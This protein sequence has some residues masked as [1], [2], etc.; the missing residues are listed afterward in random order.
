MC[1][2][3]FADLCFHIL[4]GVNVEVFQY[5]Q[6]CIGPYHM[7]V[8]CY[9]SESPIC[10]TPPP[11]HQVSN[12]M[13]IGEP[14]FSTAFTQLE[15]HLATQWNVIIVMFM[16]IRVHTI[17]KLYPSLV[18]FDPFRPEWIQNR[19]FTWLQWKVF[20]LFQKIRTNAWVENSDWTRNCM[21]AWRLSIAYQKH[22]IVCYID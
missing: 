11:S 6:T 19:L 13:S 18:W 12:H 4:I 22:W 1:Y 16:S 21:A 8:I 15:R 5:R 2:S 3:W 14:S 20:I 7:C 9:M 17:E 10:F